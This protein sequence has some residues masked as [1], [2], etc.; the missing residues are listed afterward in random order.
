MKKD[1]ILKKVSRFG[2]RI[3]PFYEW[4]YDKGFDS[5]VEVGTW[6]GQSVFILT[7]LVKENKINMKIYFIDNWDNSIKEI[8]ANALVGDIDKN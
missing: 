6:M 5:L 7:D 4:V 1:I 8:S 2:R 3:I